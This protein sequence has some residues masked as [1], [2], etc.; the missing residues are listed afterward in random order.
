MNTDVSFIL[1]K[2]SLL[3]ISFVSGV[4]AQQTVRKSDCSASSWKDTEP[5]DG[6]GQVNALPEPAPVLFCRQRILVNLG[7]TVLCV[8]GPG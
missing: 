2:S 4:R 5:R 3:Q 1:E 8:D 6:Y 7:P